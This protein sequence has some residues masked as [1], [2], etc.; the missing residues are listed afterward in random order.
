MSEWQWKNEIKKRDGYVCRRCGFDKNLHVH[1]ILPKDKYPYEQDYPPNGLTLCGNCHS[2]LKDKEEQTDLRSFLPDDPKIDEQLKYLSENASLV[3]KSQRMLLAGD[4]SQRT[5]RLGENRFRQA[6][7]FS[8]QEEYEEAIALYDDAIR[9]K[10]DFVEAYYHRGKAK[11]ELKQYK[12]AI[13][14]YD[15]A[16]RLKPDNTS[17]YFDRGKA[18]CALGQY[19]SMITDYNMVIQFTPDY[20]SAYF[21]RGLAKYKLDQH[22]AAI[23]DFDEAISLKPDF[24]KAYYYRGLAKYEQK[25]HNTALADFV[26]VT[27]LDPNFRKDSPYLKFATSEKAIRQNPDDAFAYYYRGQ[28]KAELGQHDAART[29]YDTA[30]R[31][32]PRI[33]YDGLLREI[34]G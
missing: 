12:A 15:N 25:L 7:E 20:V 31:L 26:E 3:G 9:L 11:Y 13:Y 22:D 16:L 30:V 5:N 34:F 23:T 18:K 10:S 28:A 14:D 24:A 29:D 8:D 19:K 33:Y 4:K 27:R 32:S 21:N 17:V 2:L 1:H 6:N